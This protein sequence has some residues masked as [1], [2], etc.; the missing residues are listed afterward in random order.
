MLT[1]QNDRLR[2]EIAEPGEAP[3]T[4]FRFDRAG[5]IADVVLDGAHS[6]CTSEPLNLIHPSSGGRGLCCEYQ[7]DLSGEVADG[8]YYP[9]FGVGLIRKDGAYVFH[10]QYADVREFPVR[11]ETEDNGITFTTEPVE[12]LGYALRAVKKISLDGTKIMLEGQIENAGEKELTIREYC[13]NFLSPGGM[14]IS[15]DYQFLFPTAGILAGERAEL[16][17]NYPGPV[18]FEF[19]RDGVQIRR[20]ETAVSLSDIPVEHIASQNPFCYTLLHKSTGL[21]VHGEDQIDV[22][23][24]TLWETDHVFS[25]EIFQTISLSAT[26]KAAWSRSWTFVRE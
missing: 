10:R 13:H 3:N 19:T 18:N 20:C 16:K 23:G 7:C 4:G 1:L 2:V 26:E 21:S 5:F 24:I 25:P 17:N 9:K 8:E 12:C 6:F 14:A 22:S 15:P 11:I